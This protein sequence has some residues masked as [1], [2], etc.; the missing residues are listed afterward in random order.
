[1]KKNHP[2]QILAGQY[3]Q[4]CL[5]I[6]TDARNTPEYQDSVLRGLPV[7]REPDFSFSDEDEL[8]KESTPGILK[9]CFWQSV[10][11]SSMLT[12]PWPIGANR[13]KSRIPLVPVSSPA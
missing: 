10:R 5:P 8:K 7:N 11:T 4:L 1:M 12:G 13:L 9:Y 3:P 6:M 2:I